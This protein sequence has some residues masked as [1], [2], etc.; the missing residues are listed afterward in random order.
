MV[1]QIMQ[2]KVYVM[3]AKL[4]T[5]NIIII[6]L[7]ITIILMGIGF[8]IMSV[9]LNKYTK[10]KQFDVSIRNVVKGTTTGNKTNPISAYKLLDN[11]KTVKFTFSLSDITDSINYKV[12]IKNNGNIDAKIDNIVF[13]NNYNQ[14]LV[15]VKNNNLKGKV[16]KKGEEDNLNIEI[17]SKKAQ[18]QTPYSFTVSILSSSVNQ[19]GYTKKTKKKKKREK[20]KTS[21][22][23][24]LAIFILLIFVVLVLSVMIVN[25]KNE[26]NSNNIEINLID[27]DNIV[28]KIDISDIGKKEVR[29]YKLVIINKTKTNNYNLSL[30]LKNS[31]NYLIKVFKE[32]SKNNLLGDDNLS[33]DNISLKDKSK[34]IIIIRKIDSKVNSKTLDISINK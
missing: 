25:K 23:I 28:K 4:K 7:C 6:I 20:I 2:K 32:G 30:K 14:D 15:E 11:N 12:T 33:I 29:E 13:S 24:L 22:K 16:L 17:V 1:V 19:E 5:K 26:I 18:T 8:S 31:D 21:E 10:N 34:Y 27:K 9:D 3:R